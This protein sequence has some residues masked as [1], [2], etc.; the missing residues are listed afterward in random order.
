MNYEKQAMKNKLST[1]NDIM[2]YF[3]KAELYFAIHR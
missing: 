3:V 2:S 1:G